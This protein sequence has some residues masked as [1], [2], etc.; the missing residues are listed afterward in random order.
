MFEGLGLGS[1]L[2]SLPLP[3]RYNWGTS[4][5][6]PA[7]L[8]P[9]AHR[10]RPLAG[11]VPFA[12]SVLYACITPLGIAIGLGVRNTYNPAS[13]TA[14]IVSG[15]LDSLSCGILLWAILQTHLQARLCLTFLC[16]Q[17]HR[18][19]RAVSARLHL[20]PRE[21]VN[22]DSLVRA[23][24]KLTSYLVLEVAVEASNAKVAA[25]VYAS[26]FLLPPFPHS[27]LTLAC[28]S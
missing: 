12:A 26:Y 17:I 15:I 2:S 25:S 13:A 22:C 11:A 5:L 19:C 9:V 1:R 6:R 24:D 3:S 14:S 27:A 8:E 10:P 21:S 4:P 7:G 28:F 23:S 16:E 18:T 20:Q